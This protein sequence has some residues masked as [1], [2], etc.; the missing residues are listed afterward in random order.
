[1]VSLSNHLS[2]LDNPSLKLSFDKLRT[3]GTVNNP[4]PAH[5]QPAHGEPVE[6]SFP[7]GHSSLKPSFDKLRMSGTVNNPQSAHHQPAHGELVEPPRL[8]STIIGRGGFITYSTGQPHH[9]PTIPAI[10]PSFR[11]KPESRTLG[12]RLPFFREDFL[13]S[14]FRRNDGYRR[15]NDGCRRN[16]GC[17]K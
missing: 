12:N 17:L 2:L 3:S 7:T 11:R 6:P 8:I 14:G 5:Q 13:D 15:R 1:M 16:N 10:S 9:K 4:Q